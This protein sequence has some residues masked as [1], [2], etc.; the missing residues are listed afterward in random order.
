M[1]ARMFESRRSWSLPSASWIDAQKSFEAVQRQLAEPA[2]ERNSAQELFGV[3][4]KMGRVSQA[5][6]LLL[7]ARVMKTGTFPALAFLVLHSLVSMGRRY[8]VLPRVY[9]GFG[10]NLKLSHFTALRIFESGYSSRHVLRK[11]ES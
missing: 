6:R 8:A 2:V 4:G 7:S 11:R 9:A 5:F 3:H 1:I 10:E